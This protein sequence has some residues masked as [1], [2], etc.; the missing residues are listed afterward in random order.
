MC[1]G[2][3]EV[4]G[5]QPVRDWVRNTGGFVALTCS[6]LNMQHLVKLDQSIEKTLRMACKRHEFDQ[7][8]L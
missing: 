8:V 5:N 3:W 1:T 2:S 7:K 6:R 4:V